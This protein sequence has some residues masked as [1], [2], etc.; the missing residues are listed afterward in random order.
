[1]NTAKDLSPYFREE[2]LREA[3]ILHGEA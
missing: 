2:V 3:E 1:L